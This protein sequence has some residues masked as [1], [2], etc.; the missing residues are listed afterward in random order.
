MAPTELAKGYH[1]EAKRG[2][3]DDQYLS[4]ECYELGKDG[5]SENMWMAAALYRKAA[6]QGHAES[7][8]QLGQMYYLGEGVEQNLELAVSWYREAANQGDPEGQYRLG[9]CFRFGMGVKEN[10]ESA[11]EWL[12]KAADAGIAGAQGN[13]GSIYAEAQNDALAVSWWEKAA[14]LGD[15][16]SQYRLGRCYMNGEHSILMDAK[17]AKMYVKAAAKDGSAASTRAIEA[18]KKLRGGALELEP[19][20]C[21]SCG[22]SGENAHRCQGC[23]KVRYCNRACQ[24]RHWASHRP[25][26]G[27]RKACLCFTCARDRRSGDVCAAVN[28]NESSST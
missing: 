8:S 3:A 19:G 13:L 26:C 16:I 14:V 5:L 27:A 7:Q 4:G 20:P 18:L 12:R 28:A 11:V 9:C 1:E 6:E 24:K 17:R 23:S 15:G 10:N 25:D 21:A 22:A 2:L